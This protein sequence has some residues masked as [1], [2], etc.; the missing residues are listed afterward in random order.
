MSTIVPRVNGAVH[1]TCDKEV[2]FPSTCSVEMS[3]TYFS[4]DLIQVSGKS[5]AFMMDFNDFTLGGEYPITFTDCG[6]TTQ[7]VVTIAAGTLY[8]RSLR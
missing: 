6:I 4:S 3:G 8:D 2:V 7:A 1:F 5:F